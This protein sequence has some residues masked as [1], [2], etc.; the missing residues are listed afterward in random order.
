MTYFAVITKTPT[1]DDGNRACSTMYINPRGEEQVVGSRIIIPPNKFEDDLFAKAI[2][3]VCMNTI[4]LSEEQVLF[5][6]VPVFKLGE[7]LVMDCNSD[8][9]IPDGRKPSKWDVEYE[10]F[11]D[12][13]SA[14]KRAIEVVE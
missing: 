7:I 2:T 5:C 8:R 6:M 4:D 13:E 11:N 14:V 1:S 3:S 12:I 10:T 9:T